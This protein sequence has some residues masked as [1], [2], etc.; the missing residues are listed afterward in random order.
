MIPAI[1]G[2][3]SS[4][5]ATPATPD[6]STTAGS[7]LSAIRSTP[8][9]AWFQ[10]SFAGV[11]S[12]VTCALLASEHVQ[13][14]FREVPRDPGVDRAERQV[15]GPRAVGVD[16]V[17]DRLDL[18]RAEVRREAVAVGPQLE[19]P[20]DDTEVLPPL[21]GRD[22]LARAP[23][24]DD[25]RR[26]LVG[27]ARPRRP[28]RRRR[29]CGARGRGRRVPSR[30]RRT[31]PARAPASRG[32]VGRGARR[33]PARRRR[34]RRCAPTTSRRRRREPGLLVASAHLVC[35]GFRDARWQVRTCVPEPCSA[36]VSGRNQREVMARRGWGRTGWEG[37][38]SRG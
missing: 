22:G 31:R 24:P 18:Q 10:A 19:A 17:E 16:R 23:V 20:T 36:K 4:A 7:M 21:P 26:T 9:A 37:R 2:A 13:R 11:R 27:D 34:R 35:R 12:A 29:G 25:R 30:R 32:A 1:G 38:A 3:P 33:R 15:V 6:E 28:D 8:S 5:L 14:A